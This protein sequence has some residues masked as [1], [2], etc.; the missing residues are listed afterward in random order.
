MKFLLPILS[1][2]YHMQNA[3][4]FPSRTHSSFSNQSSKSQVSIFFFSE[5]LSIQFRS[6]NEVIF[7]PLLFFC[8]FNS[9][10][11]TMVTFSSDMIDIKHQT[12]FQ[13]LPLFGRNRLAWYTCTCTIAC[14][15]AGERCFSG[16]DVWKIDSIPF[17]FLSVEIARQVHSYCV[18]KDFIYSLHVRKWEF[19]LSGFRNVW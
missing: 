5:T 8:L 17:F 16:N 13:L 6:E 12:I 11:I 1:E 19:L 15:H 3:R 4:I 18:M 7:S 2:T 10:S 9:P 14:S